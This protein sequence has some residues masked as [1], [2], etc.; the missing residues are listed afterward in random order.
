M[1]AL[2][3]MKVTTSA[4]AGGTK[5]YYFMSNPLLYAQIGADVGISLAPNTEAQVIHRVQDLLLYGVLESLVV[6]TGTTALNRK[7]TKILCAVDKVADAEKNLNGQTIPK[8]VIT[9][10]ST[11]LKAQNYLP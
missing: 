7:S 1:V 9:S 5:S 6:R 2:K 3:K 4:G 8:G 10:I 11:D